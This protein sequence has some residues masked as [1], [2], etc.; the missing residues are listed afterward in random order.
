VISSR[1]EPSDLKYRFDAV[2]RL[3]QAQLL[4]IAGGSERMESLS[5]R[6]FLS[7]GPLWWVFDWQG[8]EQQHDATSVKGPRPRPPK[9]EWNWTPEKGTVLLID[10]IDKADPDLPNGLLESLGNGEFAVPYVNDQVRCSRNNQPPLIIITTNEERELPAAFVRR[11]LVLH[12]ALPDGD[13]LR[14][15]L[16]I[17]G[18][19]HFGNTIAEPVY[20]RAAR[21][22]VDERKATSKDELVRPGQAEYLDLLRAVLDVTNGNHELQDALLDELSGYALRKNAGP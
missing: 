10:E 5:E 6:R 18:R 1:T 12:L 9:P 3:G 4:G 22:L 21:L 20:D 7:P 13:A 8:A 17:R 15:W 19:A 11:C 14:P 2:A 16:V